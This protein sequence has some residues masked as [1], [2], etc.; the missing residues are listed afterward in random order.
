MRCIVY[1]FMVGL[2]VGAA[3]CYLIQDNNRQDLEAKVEYHRN[4][5]DA[6]KIE[7]GR[8]HDLAVSADKRAEE[9]EKRAS[10]VKERIVRIKEEIP[11]PL[12]P[13]PSVGGESGSKL[14]ELVKEQ[15]LLIDLQDGQIATLKESIN[16]R[17]GEIVSLKRALDQA[18]MKANIQAQASKAALD[19]LKR[20]RWIDRSVSF[21][22]GYTLSWGIHR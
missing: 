20:S 18:D 5:E 2:V 22:A 10:V 21:A 7:A 9:I 11:K 1:S 8:Y 15:E 3:G 4:L 12:D 14:E 19:G 16:A 6:A 17:D 13:L